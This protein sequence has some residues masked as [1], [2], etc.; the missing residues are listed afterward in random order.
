MPAS[1]TAKSASAKGKKAATPAQLRA[2][3][4]E[5]L[6]ALFESAPGGSIAGEEE[7]A[8]F[9][10]RVLAQ[11]AIIGDGEEVAYQAMRLV[12]DTMGFATG[13]EGETVDADVPWMHPFYRQAFAQVQAEL[14]ADRADREEEGETPGSAAEVEAEVEDEVDQLVDDEVEEVEEVAKRKS[15]RARPSDTSTAAEPAVDIRCVYCAAHPG[16]GRCVLRE[17][18]TKCDRCLLGRQGCRAIEDKTPYSDW[19]EDNGHTRAVRLDGVVAAK[20]IRSRGRTSDM[21]AWVKTAWEEY[22][23][24]RLTAYQA[25]EGS[26]GASTADEASWPPS[27]KSTKRKAGWFGE[28]VRYYVQ[29]YLEKFKDHHFEKETVS[30][31]LARQQRMPNAK[32]TPFAAETEDDRLA[33]VSKIRQRIENYIKLRSPNNSRQKKNSSQANSTKPT[34]GL[35]PTAKAPVT[36]GFHEFKKSDHA[37]KPALPVAQNSSE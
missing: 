23:A 17:G 4:R 13:V 28:A 30:D 15:K 12:C 26:L 6:S 2:T 29:R 5:E 11:L 22:R 19:Y 21:P 35:L 1:T 37:A 3:A 20:V 14:A 10:R 33:R 27:A 24:K 16:G 36:T 7:Y 8:E 34:A 32:I 25:G 9:A 18:F 31:Y